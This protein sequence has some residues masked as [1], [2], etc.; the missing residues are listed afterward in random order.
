MAT[1]QKLRNKA[2]VLLAAVIFIALASFVLGDLLQ[3]GGSILRGKQMQIGKIDGESIDYTEFQA[4]YDEIAKIYKSNNQ[5]NNLDENAHQQILNQAWENIV[6]DKIMSKIYDELGIEIT[7]EEVFDMVQGKNLH[8]IISQIFGDPQTRQVNKANVI[9]FLKYIEENPDAPQKESWLNIEDQIITTKKMSKYTDLVSKA[10]YANS[11]QAKISIPENNVV[12]NMKF[13]QKKYSDVPDSEVSYKESDLKEYY[14]SNKESFK[15][16]AKRT[17]SYVVYNI[18]PSTEDDSEALKWITEIKGEFERA[19]DNVQFVNMNAD[20]RF[21]G[22]YQTPK[23]I[24]SPISDWVT[25]AN[26]NDVYGPI[27]DGNIYK[28]FKLNDTKVLPDS[29]QASHILIRVQSAEEEKK[30]EA[31]LDSIKEKIDAGRVTFEQAAKDNS[32]DGSAEMG[33][34]LGWFKPGMMVPEFDKAAFESKKGEIVKVKTQFGYHLLKVTNQGSTSKHYQL[35]IVDREVTASTA[36]YQKLYTEASKFA[37][38]SQDLDGFRKYAAQQ[39]LN[40][41][42]I[43]VAENDR[44]IA[45]IGA[46]RAII[47]PSFTETEVG[48]LIIGGDRSPVFELE[49]KFVVAA[50]V[51]SEEEGI[52]EFAKVKAAVELAVIKEKKQ[53]KLFEKFNNAKSSSIESTAS[54]L[55]LQVE[56]ASGFRLAFGSVNAI[57]YE[58]VV[59]GAVAALEVNQ[60]SN[61]IIGR[62]GVY[63]IQLTN[64]SGSTTGNIETEKKNLYQTLNYRASYQAF[65]TIKE[66]TDIVDKR[67]KFY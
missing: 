11:L 25:Y 35:A 52:Q 51:S 46:A 37:A 38:N 5:T 8:P 33:G 20:T 29:V 28:L 18:T 42:T 17:I 19:T 43:T 7:S 63:M 55:G 22:M 49:N 64:K 57:G 30:A 23:E 39:Q 2:G 4:K 56:E 27:R 44:S 48:E 54:S 31:K 36:T 65:E 26:V 9:Q 21:S 47:R 60:V 50:L 12:A 62:N 10:L 24:I 59:N 40:P 1:L 45:G 6:Q 58:P 13:I 53:E 61:P 66:N 67:Y 3:S 41:Q 16:K 15:Q 34:D 32:Q 14:E